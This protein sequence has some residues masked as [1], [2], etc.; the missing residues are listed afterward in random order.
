[1]RPWEALGLGG[2]GSRL[3]PG[4]C[5]VRAMPPFCGEPHGTRRPAAAQTSPQPDGAH[6]PP[7]AGCIQSGRSRAAPWPEGFEPG[8]G[9]QRL[10]LPCARPDTDNSAKVASS[11]T[12]APDSAPCPWAR[13]GL[14]QGF[15]HGKAQPRPGG[16]LPEFPGRSPCAPGGAASEEPPAGFEPPER[17]R[18][19]CEALP[20]RTE[21][22][23]APE[24]GGIQGAARS[25]ES[26]TRSGSG[27][28]G[29]GSRPRP[30][31]LVP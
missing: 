14:A 18:T 10:R 28:W 29:V 22:S 5:H 11:L 9:R 4:T 16:S 26:P 19:R 6:R 21:G 2:F 25:Q 15:G 20:G 7:C 31:T 17:H 30:V 1:M 23:R 24:A 27:P 3:G 8:A 13:A 12:R